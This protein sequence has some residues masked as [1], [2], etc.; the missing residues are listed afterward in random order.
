ML[1][2]SSDKNI[3]I[4]LIRYISHQNFLK[5]R[6]FRKFPLD[7]Q[8]CHMDISSFGYTQDDVVYSWTSPQPVSIGEL[9]INDFIL[10]DYKHGYRNVTTKLGIRSALSLEFH[11]GRTFGFY[12]LRTYFPLILIVFCSWVSFWLVR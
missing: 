7:S 9:S 11:L 6:Y 1:L 8:S 4:Y 2:Q 3:Y 12:F 5:I 10:L